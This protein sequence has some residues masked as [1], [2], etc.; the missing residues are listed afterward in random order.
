MPGFVTP[1]R[2][3]FA[4]LGRELKTVL[5]L[6]DEGWTARTL[7]RW[8]S[9]QEL[10]VRCLATAEELREALLREPVAMVIA[11]ERARPRVGSGALAMVRELAPHA[12]RCL[13]SADVPDR[14]V[15]SAEFVVSL[16]ELGRIVQLLHEE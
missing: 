14:D 8:L 16:P 4:A 7:T 11:D 13:L 3:G 5:V 2:S 15:E 10:K 6:A 12:I 1:F 9:L